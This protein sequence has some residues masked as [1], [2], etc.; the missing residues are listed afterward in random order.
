ME[1]AHDD[2]LHFALSLHFLDV[3]G[4]KNET[5]PSCPLENLL[6]GLSMFSLTVRLDSA[7]DNE[8]AQWP[9]LQLMVDDINM[10]I[11]SVHVPSS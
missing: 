6:V 10:S 8:T 11:L 7:C 5:H 1:R 9:L 4:C 2:D 3:L